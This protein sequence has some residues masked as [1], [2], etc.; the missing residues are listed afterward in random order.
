MKQSQ[1]YSVYSD[2]MLVWTKS[3]ALVTR[4]VCVYVDYVGWLVGG[5]GGEVDGFMSRRRSPFH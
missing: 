3:L 2:A 5:G 4:S 1:C